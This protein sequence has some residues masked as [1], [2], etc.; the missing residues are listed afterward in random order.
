ML[1]LF[2][3]DL[4]KLLKGSAPKCRYGQNVMLKDSPNASDVYYDLFLLSQLMSTCIYNQAQLRH[5]FLF[6]QQ[7]PKGSFLVSHVYDLITSLF[8]NPKR[9]FMG[10]GKFI[11]ILK[12]LSKIPKQ[13]QT[14]YTEYVLKSSTESLTYSFHYLK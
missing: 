6:A 5:T 10:M 12:L 13:K 9:I 7:S 4:I 1:I 8:L 11:S 14:E 2:S 3:I